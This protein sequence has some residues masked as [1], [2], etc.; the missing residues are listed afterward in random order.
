MPWT[1]TLERR[2][3]QTEYNTQHHIT[4]QSIK[5]DHV[6]SLEESFGIAEIDHPTQA[7]A[8]LPKQANV[9]DLERQIRECK[10]NMNR[11]AQELRFERRRPFS[12]HTAILT[13]PRNGPIGRDRINTQSKGFLNSPSRTPNSHVGDIQ[14]SRSLRV[15]N[16]AVQFVHSLIQEHQSHERWTQQQP[17]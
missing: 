11:A 7:K 1:I 10:A 15:N 9:A 6:L 8:E 3:H 13:E 4:P 14:Y 2:K 5:R 12:R 16:E 17:L